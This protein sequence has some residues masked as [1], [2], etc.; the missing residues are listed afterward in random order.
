M[1]FINPRKAVIALCCF[2][3]KDRYQKKSVLCKTYWTIWD[4]QPT[5]SSVFFL[6]VSFFLFFPKLSWL[7]SLFLS[8]PLTL[9][10]VPVFHPVPYQ[11]ILCSPVFSRRLKCRRKTSFRFFLSDS[12]PGFGICKPVWNC[13]GRLY[14]LP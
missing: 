3:D 8:W 1:I 12:V 9:Q 10:S 7:H 13:R 4:L 6:F 14:Q 2:W 11:A 5:V